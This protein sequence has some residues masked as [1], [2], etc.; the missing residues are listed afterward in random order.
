MIS[1]QTQVGEEFRWQEE[2][3][4]RRSGT[5]VISAIRT[6]RQEGMSPEIQDY[7]ALWFEVKGLEG[8][9]SGQPFFIMLG[10]DGQTYLYGHKVTVSP[11]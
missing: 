7:S 11:L 2:T 5:A 9:L 6:D 3:G 4:E 8:S 10:T 1:Q